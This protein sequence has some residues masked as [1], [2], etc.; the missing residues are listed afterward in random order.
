MRVRILVAALVLAVSGVGSAH[1]ARAGV[2]FVNACAGGGGS[3]NNNLF[4]P[5]GANR[6]GC[7]PGFGL[8][9][10]APAPAAAGGSSGWKFTAPPG[11]TIE[12]YTL[13]YFSEWMG[14]GW[15]SQVDDGSS[16]AG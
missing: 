12:G 8:W 14:G 2:F 6:G 16:F 4:V 5:F 11:T 13:G 15:G 10:D 3:G 1:D 9:A 7:S